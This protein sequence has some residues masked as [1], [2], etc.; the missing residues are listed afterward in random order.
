MTTTTQ[1]L[2]N[3]SVGFLSITNIIDTE[4]D[5]GNT[6]SFLASGPFVL[7]DTDAFGLSGVE[8]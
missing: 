7:T 3:L 8:R 2:G 5:T 4:T 1:N 6:T